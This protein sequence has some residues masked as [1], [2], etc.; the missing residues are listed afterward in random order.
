MPQFIGEIFPIPIGQGGLVGTKDQQSIQPDKLIIAR[1]ISYEGLTLQKEGGAAKYNSSAISG[2]PTVL[3]GWDWWP[4]DGTQRMVVVL[5]DGTIKK[6]SGSG[7][8]GT[9]LASGLTMTSVVPFFVEGGKEA[10]AGNRKLFIYTGKNAVQVLS[11]DGATT[12]A[13]ATPP[14]DWSGS[15]QPTFGLIHEGRQW[16][17]GNLNDPHRVYYSTTTNHEDMTGAGSGSISVYPGEGEKLV[18]GLSFK[19]LV[20]LWKYPTGIYIIDTTDPSATNWKVRRL[21]RSVGGASPQCWVEVDNDVIFCDPTLNWHLLSAVQEFGDAAASN[22]TRKDDIYAFIQANFSLSRSPFVKGLYYAAKREA[23]FAVSGT[24]ESVNNVRFVLDF[25]RNDGALRFRYS[26]RDKPESIWLR[27]D[28]NNVQRVVIGDNAGFVWKLDEAS[29]SKDGAAYSGSFQTPHLDFSYVDPKLSTVRKIGQFLECVV[30]PTGN[31]NLTVDAY[32][33]GVL[34][35]TLQF[36]MGS[37]GAVLGSFVLGTDKLA[38]SQIINR[39]RRLVGSGRRLSLAGTNGGVNEDF[40]VGHF[41]LHCLIG[42]ER[43]GRDT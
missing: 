6:D 28:T 34:V 4:T 26:D 25:N 9:T 30:T 39:K 42:D 40:S 36:N 24:G 7:A 19:G 43:L 38:G 41:M 16:G 8:F 32:W 21:S 11:G 10:A 14:A 2:A 20:I 33:D 1:N 35:Q 5:S 31:W 22:I 17:A 23:H 3:G 29:K 13:I 37:S 12:A 27:K 18:A 15:N